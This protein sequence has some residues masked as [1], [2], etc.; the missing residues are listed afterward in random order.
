MRKPA[1]SLMSAIA[2]GLLV[3]GSLVS[4]TGLVAARSDSDPT[5]PSS[6]VTTSLVSGQTTPGMRSAL[7]LPRASTTPIQH[8]VIFMMENHSFDNLFGT[9]PGAN[10]MIEP[11]ATDGMIFDPDH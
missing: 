4:S 3:L 1:R 8:V 11:H 5:T 7:I 6:A 2:S 9:F 10:G